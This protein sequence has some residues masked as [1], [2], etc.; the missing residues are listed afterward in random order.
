MLPSHYKYQV[1]PFGLTNEPAF[2]QALI[3]NVLRDFLNMFVFVYLNDILIF[4]NLVMN[5]RLKSSSKIQMDPHKVKAITVWPT[6]INSYP[7]T[8]VLS[9]CHPRSNL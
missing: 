8:T 1:V 4:L 2:F 5:K 9:F 3:N 6:P 7:Q